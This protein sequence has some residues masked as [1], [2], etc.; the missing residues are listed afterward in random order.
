[1]KLEYQ[2]EVP[3]YGL[4]D[5]VKQNDTSEDINDI[6]YDLFADDGSCLNEGNVF[7]EM[8][9]KEEVLIFLSN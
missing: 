9:T 4:V 8:P 6:F 2:L 7:Y 5:V 1:M 3:N